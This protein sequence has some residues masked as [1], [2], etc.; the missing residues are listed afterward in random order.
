MILGHPNAPTH[1]V[2]NS[3]FLSVWVKTRTQRHEPNGRRSDFVSVSTY[4]RPNF[5]PSLGRHGRARS[6]V[7]LH[8]ASFDPPPTPPVSL[9]PLF[10]LPF[11]LSG[12]AVGGRVAYFSAEG[13]VL[14]GGG[15][16]GA[17]AVAGGSGAAAA[18]AGAG[19]GRCAGKRIGGGAHLTGMAELVHE[20][21]VVRVRAG[22]TRCVR[23]AAPGHVRVAAPAQA[24]C[25]PIELLRQRDE[26]SSGGAECE[27]AAASARAER[28]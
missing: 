23:A 21:D 17:A 6:S 1:F 9:P 7:L 24:A 26:V 22:C 28:A 25:L 19:S 2:Q 12:R 8:F 4:F 10:S 3:P 5:G 15:R 27:R 11:S 20:L 18:A 13:G 16:C 14:L